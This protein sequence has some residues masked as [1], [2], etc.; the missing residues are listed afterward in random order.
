[1]KDCMVE[2]VESEPAKLGEGFSWVC[3]D[4]DTKREKA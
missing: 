3:T 2:A 4:T 1:M